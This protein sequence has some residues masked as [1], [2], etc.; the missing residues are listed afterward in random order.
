MKLTNN[1]AFCFKSTVEGQ[2][3]YFGYFT[4]HLGYIDSMN[5]YAYCANNPLNYTDPWGEA[6]FGKRP[7]TGLP[8]LDILSDNSLGDWI[9][10]ELSHEQIWFNDGTNI[11][12]F[13]D[14]TVRADS[15]PREKYCSWREGQYDDSLVWQAIENVKKTESF[16]GIPTYTS[17]YTPWGNYAVS[18][19]IPDYSLGGNNCQGFCEAVRKEYVNLG[20]TVTVGDEQ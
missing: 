6:K 12:W 18:R 4:D 9:D 2:P 10:M 1:T 17:P 14:S 11:G 8:W 3:R 19:A 5:L 13:N 16:D 20:G 7:L 15:Q